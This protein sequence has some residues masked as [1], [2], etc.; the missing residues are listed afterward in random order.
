MSVCERV[1]APFVQL[2]KAGEQSGLSD[3]FRVLETD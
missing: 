1:E 2:S 3:D